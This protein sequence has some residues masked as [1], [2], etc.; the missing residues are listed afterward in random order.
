[1]KAVVMVNKRCWSFRMN[2][3]YHIID[4]I[5]RNCSVSVARIE[6]KVYVLSNSLWAQNHIR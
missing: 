6:R 5:A 4:A 3:Y 1:M 2:F